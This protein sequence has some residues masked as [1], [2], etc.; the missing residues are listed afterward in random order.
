[1][2]HMDEFS[3][4]DEQKF[5]KLDPKKKPLYIGIAAFFIV[6]VMPVLSYLYYKTALNRPAQTDKEITFKIEKGEG[7]SSISD[8]LY[9]QELVNSK[10]LFD[11]YVVLN[12]LQSKIQA[13]TYVIPAGYNVKQLVE[14]F[15]KGKDDVKVTFLEGWRV[16]EIAQLASE[17]FENVEYQSF[18]DQ[19][20]QYEGMLFP[21]TYEFNVDADEETIINA[22]WENFDDKTKEVLGNDKLVGAGLSADQVLIL[23]SIVEREAK[24]SS[25]R[26]IVA[27]ILE[28]RLKIGMALEVDATL[29]YALGYSKEEKTWWRKNL[30]QDD[31]NLDS[32]FNTR[33]NAG[34]PPGPICSPGLD[35][36]KAVV[37]PKQTDDLYYVSDKKGNMHYAQTLD[38]H[39]QN[40]Q[41]YL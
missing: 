16:E 3:I 39:V 20:R 41:N 8:R 5:H 37:Y 31:L 40:I 25:D 29:Q 21:D 22:V 1:M 33:K 23:A 13:G 18:V 28:K 7:V 15:Q 26:P 32:P 2:F 19:A 35:A 34:L 30:T 36:I 4:V 9:S 24:F 12:N 14:L 10:A 17:K 38:K 27:G 11:I 6:V